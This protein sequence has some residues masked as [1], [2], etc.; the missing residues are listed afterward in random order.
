MVSRSHHTALFAGVLPSCHSGAFSPSEFSSSPAFFI[1]SPVEKRSSGSF[2]F[3]GSVENL[4]PDDAPGASPRRCGAPVAI[5][6]YYPDR[7]FSVIQR[8]RMR[9]RPQRGQGWRKGGFKF[10]KKGFLQSQF[11][12]CCSD[13]SGLVPG[14]NRSVPTVNVSDQPP[15][16]T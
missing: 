14:F 5:M 16:Q 1:Q 8:N 10:L 4:L 15:T 6:L 7:D 12:I 9:P 11:F 3:F 13:G 2:S